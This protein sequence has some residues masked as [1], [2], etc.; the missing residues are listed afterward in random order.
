MTNLILVRAP[1]WLG[2]AVMS[3]PFL[4]RLAAR[5]P[6]SAIDVL[7]RPSTAELYRASGLCRAVLPLPGVDTA[8]HRLRTVGYQRAYVL[9]PSFSAAWHLWRAGIPERVGLATDG[10]SRLLTRPIPLD[11][12]YHYVRRYLGLLEEAHRDVSS[13]DLF[14]PRADEEALSRWS[15]TAGIP[16]P[17]G[18]L[19][20]APGSRASARRWFPERFA[21][22]A[23]A[24]D[25]FPAV[26]LLGAPDDVP[27]ATAVTQR[28]RRP[29][30]NLCGRTPLP[31]LGSLLARCAA[32]V[33]NESG[34]MHAA[35]AI[36]TPTVVVAGPSNPRLTSPFGERVRVLQHRE[37]PC[38]P[39]VR[40]ECFRA[41]ADHLACLKTI[42]T[43]EAL[44]ALRELF[45]GHV[46]CRTPK[47]C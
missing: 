27:W 8:P 15:D 37:I 7:C 25:E 26:V 28:S 39:C 35:W 44:A 21:A 1:N 38:V 10:R 41:G 16:L 11:E 45:G 3:I 30:I 17:S 19:A 47:S 43:G 34:L 29:L 12:R 42:S 5:H 13:E 33:T 31:V 32:L 24:A 4:R 20:L 14:F 9:P 6:G 40:N 18:A 46:P 2:D 23:D 22:L 36:G